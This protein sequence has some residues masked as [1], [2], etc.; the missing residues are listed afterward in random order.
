MIGVCVLMAILSLVVACRNNPQADYYSKRTIITFFLSVFACLLIVLAMWFV[1]VYR[2]VVVSGDSMYPTYVSGQRVLGVVV[3][4]ASDLDVYDYPVCVVNLSQDVVVIKRL[5]GRPGD[6]VELVDGDTYVN[7][8]LIMQRTSSSWD[9][10][11][12]VL[13]EDEWLFLGDNREDSYD[14]RFWDK[15]TVPLSSISCYIINSGLKSR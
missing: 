7:G 12:F 2:V 14:A 11:T 8:N 4:D 9:N 5:I 15:A 10:N 3:D 1:N 13:G 6:I